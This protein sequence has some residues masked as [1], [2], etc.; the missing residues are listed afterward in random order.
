MQSTWAKFAKNPL[1]GPGWNSVGTGAA[2]T[3]MY[4][5]YDSM[6]GGMYQ[7]G[8]ASVIKGDWSL[9]VLGDVGSVRGSGA[10]VIEQ[11]DVDFRC[12]LLRPIYE[13]VVGAGAFPPGM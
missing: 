10:T 3:I 4:G 11:S 9:A 2:G 6:V 12:A 13:A 5:A 7:D 1:A 8:N